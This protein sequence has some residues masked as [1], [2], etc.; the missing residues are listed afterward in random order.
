[1]LTS[2]PLVGRSR[3]LERLADVLAGGEHFAVVL[4]GRAGVGKTRLASEWLAV[5]EARG[6]ATARVKGGQSA[7]ALPFG[8]LAPLLPGAQGP[9]VE[10]ADMLSR[11]TKDIV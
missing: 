6:R 4:A 5:A 1:M 8:A 10:P 7:R 2:W 11:A 9:S 3:E